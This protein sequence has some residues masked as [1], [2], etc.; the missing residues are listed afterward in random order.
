MNPRISMTHSGACGN[1]K[2]SPKRYVRWKSPAAAGTASQ[3]VCAKS[4]EFVVGRSIRIASAAMVLLELGDQ[5]FSRISG[6]WQGR[7]GNDGPASKRFAANPCF[8]LQA[9]K[10]GFANFHRVRLL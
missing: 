1:K 4:L 2:Y 6:L 7:G 10:C 3:R 8:L 5:I 9:A